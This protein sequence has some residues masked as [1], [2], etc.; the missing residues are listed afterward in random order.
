MRNDSKWGEWMKNGVA[1]NEGWR[2][3][4]MADT[5]MGCG[6]ELWAIVMPVGET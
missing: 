6:S 5:M 3:S 4:A 1:I 2:R